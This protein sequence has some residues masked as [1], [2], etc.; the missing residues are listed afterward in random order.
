MFLGWLVFDLDIR[1]VL[2]GFTVFTF[3]FDWYLVVSFKFKI[4]LYV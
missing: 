1:C 4:C 2:V 3:G